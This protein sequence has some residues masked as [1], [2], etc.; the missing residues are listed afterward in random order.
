MG[1]AARMKSL[2][3]KAQ[4]EAKAADE[5]NT[6]RALLNDS[7]EK[8]KA[9]DWFAREGRAKY[10]SEIE[11]VAKTGGRKVTIEV[12]KQSRS[13]KAIVLMALL[14]EFLAQ[15]GFTSTKY[16]ESIAEDSEMGPHRYD[17]CGFHVIW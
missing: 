11:K 17:V 5:E 12:S 13:T 16:H 15:E 6:R 9:K 4:A 2:V 10:L 3:E 7:L 8:D 1:E 14:E